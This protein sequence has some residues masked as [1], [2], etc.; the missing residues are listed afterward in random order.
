MHV[1]NLKDQGQVKQEHLDDIKTRLLDIIK[2]FLWEC[3]T[4]DTKSWDNW[5]LS[6]VDLKM[7]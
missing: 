7:N 4:F 6:Y 2:W 1:C 5:L 3:R